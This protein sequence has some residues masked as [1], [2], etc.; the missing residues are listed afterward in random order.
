MTVGYWADE[1]AGSQ[2]FEILIPILLMACCLAS[3]KWLNLHVSISLLPGLCYLHMLQNIQ[4][5]IIVVTVT[6]F[7]KICVEIC[8][9]L[10]NE[11]WKILLFKPCLFI[12]RITLLRLKERKTKKTKQTTLKYLVSVKT[13]SYLAKLLVFENSSPMHIRIAK[14]WFNYRSFL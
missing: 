4:R 1:R 11:G 2:N 8:A 6:I 10:F 9:H 3:G 12:T 5:G 13:G 7:T 14:C